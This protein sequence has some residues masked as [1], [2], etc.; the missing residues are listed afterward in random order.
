MT[1]IRVADFLGSWTEPQDLPEHDFPEVA[2]IG[3]SNVG[4]STLI[5][6]LVSRK[7]LAHSSSTP[8]KTRTFNVYKIAADDCSNRTR[9][10][11]FV[12][13]PGFGYAKL[14]KEDRQKFSKMIVDYILERKQLKTILLLQDCRRAPAQDE[15]S[16]LELANR[17][18][19]NLQV[20]LT[21]TDKL[22]KQEHKERLLALSDDFQVAGKALILSSQPDKLWELIFGALP[23]NLRQGD[24]L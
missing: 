12:D 14:S 24:I 23:E 21:K 9:T 1:K 7:S 16:V 3:R 4:K 18:E 22:N 5:N 10:F 2:F 17:V 13:L 8:G 20:V 15:I 11:H 6:K 19:K